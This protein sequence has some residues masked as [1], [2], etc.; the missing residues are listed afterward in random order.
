MHACAFSTAISDHG[1]DE[2]H[3]NEEVGD[4]RDIHPGADGKGKGGGSD[5]GQSQGQQVR[6]ELGYINLET[7][8]DTK[9]DTI[10]T[11]V[12]IHIIAQ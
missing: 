11:Y 12:M 3:G 7:C 8:Q 5:R 2:E 4:S 10:I 9:Y 1:H 6:E